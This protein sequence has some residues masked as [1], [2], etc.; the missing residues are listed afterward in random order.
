MTIMN[1][2]QNIIRQSSVEINSVRRRNYWGVINWYF[3][4]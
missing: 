1:Y 2:I 4:L 3:G